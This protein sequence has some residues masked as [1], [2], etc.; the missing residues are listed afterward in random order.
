VVSAEQTAEVV[1]FLEAIKAR[2]SIRLQKDLDMLIAAIED[3]YLLR[4]LGI[5]LD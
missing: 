1:Q 3:G 2:G 5:R 4:D